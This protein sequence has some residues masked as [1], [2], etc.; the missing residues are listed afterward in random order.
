M[1]E[2]I[3]YCVSLIVPSEEEEQ[4]LDVSLDRTNAK[5]SR[6]KNVFKKK[7]AI[8]DMMNI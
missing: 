4:P 6:Q 7:R 1:Y 5:D 8:I 2:I 3:N